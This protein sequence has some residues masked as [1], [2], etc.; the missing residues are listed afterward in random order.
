MIC[1]SHL[2]RLREVTNRFFFSPKKTFFPHAFATCYELLSNISAMIERFSSVYSSSLARLIIDYK[3]IY[4]VVMND[5]CLTQVEKVWSLDKI[6]KHF[7]KMSLFDAVVNHMVLYLNL[8]YWF[9]W[10]ILDILNFCCAF[11]FL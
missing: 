2:I 6:V 7:L 5:E 10:I 8:S 9:F 11:I 3:V 4:T 1:L